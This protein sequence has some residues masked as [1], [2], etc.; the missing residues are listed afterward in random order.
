ACPFPRQV[1]DD[2]LV[3]WGFLAWLQVK[4]ARLML[5]GR[6]DK[7]KVEPWTRGLATS[8]TSNRRRAFGAIRRLRTFAKA[9][10]DVLATYDVLISPT[11]ATPAPPLGHLA[12]DL[13]YETHFDRVGTFAAFT[14]LF[15]AA[16]APAISLPLGRTTTNLPLGIQ[17]A[18]ARNQDALL[19]SLAQ[20]LEQAQP[21][22]LAAPTRA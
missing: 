7:T 10:A 6:F 14:A 12:T 3:Y 17:F 19:L 16:G 11:V 5:D 9:Y 22:P 21:W 1:N 15:N 20:T 18:A 13:P 8:F 2:F 4:T